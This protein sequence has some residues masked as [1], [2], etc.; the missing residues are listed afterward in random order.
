MRT[1]IGCELDESHVE[2]DDRLAAAK[3]TA[4]D[5][6]TI[7]LRR[8]VVDDRG[9]GDPVVT[10]KG[11]DR[12]RRDSERGAAVTEQFAQARAPRRIVIDVERLG[13]VEQ[14]A[15]ALG[16]DDDR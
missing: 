13:A 2:V 5:R 7:D 8:I 6:T 11:S 12:S 10:L 4:S 3:L 16:D 14:V 9:E 15:A 1:Q